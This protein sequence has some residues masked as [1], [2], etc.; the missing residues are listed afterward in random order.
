[1]R[2]RR[3]KP[4]E[5]R[6]DLFR[7]DTKS[8]A[9]AASVGLGTLVLGLGAYVVGLSTITDM[10]RSHA[11]Y[12]AETFANFL[13]QEVGDVEGM[14]LGRVTPEVTAA[15]LGAV[16][17][18]GTVYQFQLYD[19]NG[20]LRGDSEVFAQRRVVGRG[21]PQVSDAVRT[22]IATGR[23]D[24]SLTQ[25]DGSAA[26]AYYSDIAI[27][28]VDDGRVIG[29]LQV[30]SDETVTW[31]RLFDQ[32]RSVFLQVLLLLA[33]AFAIPACLYLHQKRQLA[34]A[35][36]VLRL[37]TQYDS[38][39]GCLNRATFTRIVSELTEHAADRG[40]AV[41][42]HFIDLDRF[43]EVNEGLGHSA[44]DDLLRQ[45]ASRLR[46]LMGTR[47]RI[48]RLGADEF[49]I[50]QPYYLA[51]P[52]VVTELAEDIARDLSRPFEI[53]GSK[54]MVGAS[55]GYS[56]FPED[57]TTVDELFHA[58]DLA[59]DHAKTKVRGRAVAFDRGMES[60]R[61]LRATIEQR[62]RVSLSNGGFEVYFQPLYE[63]ATDRLRGFEALLR[64]N[65][66]NGKPISPADFIPIAED[67]GLI[68]DI[69]R[70][71]LR[72]ACRVAKHWP[73]HLSVAV[74]LSP[75]QFTSGDMPK[76]VRDTLDFS[77]IE[78]GRLELEV[79]ESLLIT[80]TDKVL[81]QLM[82]IKSLGVSVAL[83]D[84]GTG[85]S[86][87]GYLWRFP[88]DK[89]KV[90]KSFMTDL[91]EV[92]GRSREI[93]STI[94]ALGKVLDL[95]VT[96]EGVETEEQARLLRELRCDL[97]QG[98]LFGRPMRSRDLDEVIARGTSGKWPA[99]RALDAYRADHRGAA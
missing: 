70:W 5:W 51:S 11:E 17:P 4:V 96:A 59:L 32:F 81:G 41:A 1:M 86:S 50:C 31:P 21:E 89:L 25:T 16:E 14:L 63:T 99:P 18:V 64:M 78:P 34:Q 82:A 48:A 9:R 69:G 19:L 46:R 22:V 97:V 58:A 79:T 13:L 45:T 87:L 35:S 54:V 98:Y 44:G 55:L 93:L 37:S 68:N 40:L 33:L 20:V 73:A 88:F 12:V 42:I 95:K 29:A 80:D 52:Q 2:G 26:P 94:I 7:V 49:A 76:I 90:D 15:V 65:D 66:Q 85:Y 3:R 56:R 47:E 30:R 61:Q 67:T 39:S 36:K 28:F 8:V 74:N 27:P 43:K 23:V 10:Q 60:E 92:G 71:V 83:D 77:G 72:E 84:F 38:L 6:L 53:N 75:A 24:F 91:S 57:G 62:L